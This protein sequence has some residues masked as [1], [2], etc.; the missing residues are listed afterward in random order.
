[1]VPAPL[2]MTLTRALSKTRRSHR[3]CFVKKPSKTAANLCLHA[4]GYNK[5]AE[6]LALS[7]IDDVMALRCVGLTKSMVGDG[8]GNVL[9]DCKSSKGE[10]I[11][12]W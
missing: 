9:I 4:N 8:I 10:E 12:G 6:D 1:M 5:D 7:R 11:S 3:L 2:P